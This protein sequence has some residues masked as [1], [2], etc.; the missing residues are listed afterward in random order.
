MIEQHLKDRIEDIMGGAED[1]L[2]K[3]GHLVPTLFI[4][5]E[6]GI[7]VIE[8][9]YTNFEEKE[10]A[11]SNLNHMLKSINLEACFFAS[12][13]WMSK[14]LTN[15]PSQNPDKQ[16]V[17]TVIGASYNIQLSYVCLVQRDPHG[18]PISVVKTG[19]ITQVSFKLF[20][21]L[22]GNTIATA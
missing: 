19:E 14:T 15:T 6:N 13:A 12:E 20:D 17:I 2:I 8:I 11:F 7:E 4:E 18:K 16:E 22:F 10:E 3:Q 9:L 21:G 5:N 1:L